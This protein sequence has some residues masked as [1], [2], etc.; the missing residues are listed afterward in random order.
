M[1]HFLTK[2][3]VL[4]NEIKITQ[5]ENP[6]KLHKFYDE[7]RKFLINDLFVWPKSKVIHIHCF[8]YQVYSLC[9][10]FNMFKKLPFQLFG[11]IIYFLRGHGFLAPGLGRKRRGIFGLDAWMKWI[12]LPKPMTE[13]KCEE[14]NIAQTCA[15]NIVRKRRYAT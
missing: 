1:I 14:I 7:L 6:E 13:C 8:K 5:Q 15:G 3:S 2:F 11:A 4:D 10:S 9:L 12:Q